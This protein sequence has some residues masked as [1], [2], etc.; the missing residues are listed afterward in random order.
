MPPATSGTAG[1]SSRVAGPRPAGRNSA[2]PATAT[3]PI[4]TLI[5]KTQCQ[6]RP[7]TTTPPTSGPPAT[8]SP[9]IPPKMPTIVPRRSGGN[10]AAMIV[11]ASGVT[12]AAPRPCAARKAISSPEFG[13]TAQSADAT[14]NR[15]RPAT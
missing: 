9:A 6:S 5:Q 1:R 3:T 11:S 2:E 8:A 4:G 10:V 7:C 12:A 13:A 15:L 14:V